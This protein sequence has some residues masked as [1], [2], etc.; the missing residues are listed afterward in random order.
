MPVSCWPTRIQTET[1]SGIKAGLY[2]LF[3]SNL[4]GI[5]CMSTALTPTTV[6]QTGSFMT[7][8]PENAAVTDWLAA[9]AA[10]QGFVFKSHIQYGLQM[11]EILG[12]H[13]IYMNTV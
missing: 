5:M 3:L 4:T 7:E 11:L 1:F 2:G 10:M 9:A 8:R 13:S 6:R 12:T